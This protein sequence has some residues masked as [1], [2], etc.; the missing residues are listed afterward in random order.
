[1][2]VPLACRPAVV[3]PEHVFTKDMLVETAQRV[4]GDTHP[5]LKRIL[6][7][8][9]NA[10]VHK[11]HLVQS[12]ED[13]LSPQG[14]GARNHLFEETSKDLC[15]KAGAQALENAGL[16]PK[17]ID[18]IITTSCTGIMIPSVCAHMIPTMGFKRT[19]KR[20]P[21]TELGCAAG[22]VALSRAREFI[23]SHPGKNVLIVSHELCSLTYQRQ[24][25]TMQAIIGALLFG[26]GV[27]ATVVRGDGNHQGA[28]F[29]LEENQSFLFEDSWAYMGFDVKDSGLHLVLDKGIPGAV[30][31]QI[32]PVM[33][34]FLDENGLKKGDVDF[35]VMHPG[36]KKVLDE[37]ARVF[38]L[39]PGKLEASLDCLRYVGNLSSASIHVVLQNT[40][41]TYTPQHG[42]RGLLTAFGPGFSAEM[43]LGH[44]QG[45]R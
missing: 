18:L 32:A 2:N 4:L 21:I 15:V 43:I 37:I 23:L 28:G 17:D 6:K 22:A 29:T 40:F 16:T 42:Q 45:A 25:L 10:G 19:T 26:D 44:W 33:T 35:F 12:L 14:F 41:D 11:R 8:I 3:L 31:R 27:A 36:G 39:P 7:I 13:T 24:D 34:G 30:E 1:L 38:E 5:H 9:E 20:L